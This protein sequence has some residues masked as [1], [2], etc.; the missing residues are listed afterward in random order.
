MKLRGL[1]RPRI[2]VRGD[3]PTPA[4]RHADA[5]IVGTI[6]RPVPTLYDDRRARQRRRFAALALCVGLPTLVAGLYYAFIASDR[7]V[8][9]T[10]MILNSDS[11]SGG[12]LPALGKAASSGSSAS[13][14]LSLVDNSGGGDANADQEMV[15][16]YLQSNE[17]M[18]AADHAIGLRKMWNA[19]SIDLFSRLP[20]NA[21]VERFQRY[22]QHHVA[23]TSDQSDPVL[24]VQVQAFSPAD[25]QLIAQTL[26]RLGQQKLNDAY[27]QMREDSLNFARSEVARAEQRL[28]AVDNKIRDFRNAHGDI[29]PPATAG[30]VG[31]VAGTT[32]GQ[33]SSAR[34]QLQ[35]ALS[36][37]R[38]D[39]PVVQGLQSW[40]AALEKQ[41]R[42]D[43]GLLAGAEGNKNYASLL[44][45]Y[46]NLLL[47]QQLSQ[48]I[49]TS[50][51]SLL[52]SA[53]AATL[54]QHTYL[55][56]FIK[57]TTPQEAT[58]PRAVRNVLLVLAAASLAYLVGSLVVAA[59]RDHR[60][61]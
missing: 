20:V 21:S 54:R 41:M 10:Q 58:E 2:L 18:L 36:Y 37:A 39:T 5:L 34:A 30:A 53:R 27:R 56:D 1:G 45:Q 52:N 55:V 14:L 49:Y 43:R 11:G 26:V 8:S 6:T 44:G 17:A 46:E 9:E 50:A 24:K 40:I 33:L 23:V 59:L 13:S 61:L 60:H 28:A 22:Y 32:F 25:A 47:E 35:A 51:L 15:Q 16:N 3:N 48:A 31:T 57:P 19:G 4:P 29:D 12:S 42:S 7:Y 38:P